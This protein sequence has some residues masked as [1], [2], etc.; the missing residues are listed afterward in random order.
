[1]SGDVGLYLYGGIKIYIMYNSGPVAEFR[2]KMYN[3]DVRTNFYCLLNY[4]FL[5][6]KM[7]YFFN[8][9]YTSYNLM[10]KKCQIN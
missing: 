5:I 7:F 2:Q 10:N 9:E 8:G 4:F 1:M 6:T 3:D